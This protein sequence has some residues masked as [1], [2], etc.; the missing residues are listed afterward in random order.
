MLSAAAAVPGVW[1]FNA[2]GAAAAGG[3]DGRVVGAGA[4][5]RAGGDGDGVHGASA[6]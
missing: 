3:Y 4:V 5:R 2:G 6:V 1:A